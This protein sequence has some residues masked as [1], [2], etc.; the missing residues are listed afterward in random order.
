MPAITE[1]TAPSWHKSWLPTALATG[2][3]GGWWHFLYFYSSD[4]SLNIIEKACGSTWSKFKS[5]NVSRR[6]YEIISSLLFYR[7][8]VIFRPL[9]SWQPFWMSG[10]PN[11]CWY[12]LLSSRDLRFPQ[13]FKPD[14]CGDESTSEVQ[15]LAHWVSRTKHYVE[16]CFFAEFE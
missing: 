13:K 8:I 7:K 16:L 2:M 12:H 5:N 4:T 1:L 15:A 10:S 3:H 14:S 9:C 6:F 11:N